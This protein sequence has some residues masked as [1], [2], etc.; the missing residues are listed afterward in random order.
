M[1][2]IF[3]QALPAALVGVV[4]SLIAY[5]AS[6]LKKYR[7]EFWVCIAGIAAG[8]WAVPIAVVMFVLRKL[9]YGNT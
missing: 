5:Y 9:Q 3:N 1:E 8:Y 2:A 4:F 7:L 6:P